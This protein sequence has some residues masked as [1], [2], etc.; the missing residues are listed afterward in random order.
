M[1][2]SQN[3]TMNNSEDKLEL[4]FKRLVKRFKTLSEDLQRVCILKE[5][6]YSLDYVDGA[7]LI[8]IILQKGF[9]NRDIELLSPVFYLLEDESFL[10]YKNILK[11]VA[12]EENL[13]ELNTLLQE[14]E[15]VLEPPEEAR[16]PDY[17]AGR[18][19][20]LGERKAIAR[21]PSRALFDKLIM[22]PH[23]SVIR[24]LLDNPKLTERDV[25][26][27]CAIRPNRPEILK[28]VALHPRW[29]KNYNVKLAIIKNPYTPTYV[30][31]RIALFLLPQD[32][33]EIAENTRLHPALR[34]FCKRLLT[35]SGN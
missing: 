6:L 21:R 5:T 22:D 3:Q 20:T 18:P 11:T 17:G 32:L 30:S 15:P 4:T 23:P 13:E 16:V 10:E 33:N 27:L 34:K 1:Q 7:R 2:R 9:M 28:T 35:K 29:Q 31:M 26:K 8:E 14:I 19:L 25:I 12:V 24:N